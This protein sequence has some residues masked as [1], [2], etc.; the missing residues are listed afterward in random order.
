MDDLVVFVAPEAGD[1]MVL[2]EAL[3]IFG[4]ASGLLVNWAKSIA[5][6]IH[7]DV[8]QR[9]LFQDHLGCNVT[10]FPCIYLGIPLSVR[11]L[12]HADEQHIIDAVVKRIPTWKGNLLN[13]TDR[14]TLAAVT[15]SA[16]LTHV[17]IA[18]SLSPWAIQEIDK[19]RRGFL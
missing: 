3:R 14:A 11:L 6:A 1:I 13:M 7:C 12:R 9:Q 5:T 18:T 15:L 10:D 4:N 8:A 17:A 19:R 16:I 2:K